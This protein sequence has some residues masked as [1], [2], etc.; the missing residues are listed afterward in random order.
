M[1]SAPPP[2]PSLPLQKIK[3]CQCGGKTRV[4][5]SREYTVGLLYRRRLCPECGS[6]FNTYEVRLDIESIFRL[7]KLLADGEH[8][9]RAR[10]PPPDD[11]NRDRP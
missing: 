6:R 8:R 4:I 10:T 2:V 9:G 1:S 3:L 5:N 11:N 7:D